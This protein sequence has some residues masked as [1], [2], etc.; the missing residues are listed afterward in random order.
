[1][2]GLVNNIKVMDLVS[3]EIRQLMSIYEFSI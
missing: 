1:M 2:Q 3:G